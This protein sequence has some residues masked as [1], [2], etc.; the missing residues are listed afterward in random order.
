[1]PNRTE[2]DNNIPGMDI[3]SEG[4]EYKIVARKKAENDTS[5]EGLVQRNIQKQKRKDKTTSSADRK[6]ELPQTPD[7]R[8]VSVSNGIRQS[9]DT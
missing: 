9:E 3:K 4:D 2:I 6:A 8:S 5:I 7:K 1:M